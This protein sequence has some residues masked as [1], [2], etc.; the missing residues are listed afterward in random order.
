MMWS[1]FKA[2]VDDYLATQ[3]V[4][5]ARI[6]LIDTSVY[7]DRIDPRLTEGGELIVTD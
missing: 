5:D 1:E 4:N 7:P 6:D 2:I 3:G